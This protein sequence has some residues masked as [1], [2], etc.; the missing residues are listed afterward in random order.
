[1]RTANIV[2]VALGTNQGPG[3]PPLDCAEKDATDIAHLFSGHV[4]PA[5]QSALLL[6]P[7]VNDARQVLRQLVGRPP[8]VLIVFNSGHGSLKGVL[9]ADGILQYAELRD[10]ISLIGA[11]NTLVLLDVCHAGAMIKEG[12][13]GVVVGALDLGYLNA[14]ASATPGTRVFCSVGADRNAGENAEMGNGY[15]TAAVL[16]ASSIIN[17]RRPRWINDQELFNAIARISKRWGQTPIA[18]GITRNFPVIAEQ[19]LVLGS[20][21]LIGADPTMDTIEAS[22]LIY[23]RAGVPMRWRAQLATAAGRRVLAN[24][25]QR[26][27]PVDDEV[28]SVCVFA[29]PQDAVARDPMSLVH[30]RAVRQMPLVWRV[31]LEDLR[32]R[33]FDEFT[34]TFWWQP[35]RASA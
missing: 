13:S 19:R 17:A 23:D 29:L 1:M 3:A 12:L 16:E 35:W 14:L 32:G 33:V 2:C 30:L 8:D 11:R 26:F 18:R 21:T 5:T 4:G 7:R 10:W 22:A 27:V 15:F 6:S 25:E 28:E 9:L 24:L 34:H 31:A 20:A